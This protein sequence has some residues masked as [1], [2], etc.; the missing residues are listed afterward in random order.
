VEAIR[1]AG[2]GWRC[3]DVLY[4]RYRYGPRGFQEDYIKRASPE[5]VL[6]N[7]IAKNSRVEAKKAHPH[8]DRHDKLK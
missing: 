5:R 2:S 6:M 3:G 1:Y 7:K 4:F 8:P